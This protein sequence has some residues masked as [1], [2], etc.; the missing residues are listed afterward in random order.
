LNNRNKEPQGDDK[1]IA[2][3]HGDVKASKWNFGC[4]KINYNCIIFFRF[5]HLKSL[6]T[7]YPERIQECSQYILLLR[8]EFS[9]MFQDCRIM[10]QEFLLFTLHLEKAPEICNWN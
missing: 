1:L 7:T 5:P 9:K 4:G 2:E 6:D 3:M 10:E 8:E